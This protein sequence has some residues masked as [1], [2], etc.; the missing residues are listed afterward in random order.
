MK[1]KEMIFQYDT[2]VILVYVILEI[3]EELEHGNLTF[4]HHLLSFI[5]HTLSLYTSTGIISNFDQYSMVQSR[6]LDIGAACGDITR[7]KFR[8]QC[9][10]SGI[11]G[12]CGMQ[13]DFNQYWS[14]FVL[15]CSFSFSIKWCVWFMI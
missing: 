9:H 5:R 11:M 8:E 7:R 15:L 14:Y 13:I 4:R 10:C 12:I 6:D 2:V 3:L 1:S